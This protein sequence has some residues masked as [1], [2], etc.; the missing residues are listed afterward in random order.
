MVP[1]V[2]QEEEDLLARRVALQE[3][4]STAPA[5]SL[6][7]LRLLR[8]PCR[9]RL[10]P[11]PLLLRRL[12]W[13]SSRGSSSVQAVLDPQPRLVALLA[14]HALGAAVQV[15]HGGRPGARPER[16]LVR[17]GEDALLR[18]SA[19]ALA[20]AA[21]TPTT[22]ALATVALATADATTLSPAA[23]A[24]GCASARAASA[25]PLSGLDEFRWPLTV[26]G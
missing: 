22:T 16:L 23:C 7:L 4:A 17:E 26:T 19:A 20:G 2:S 15:G 3:A 13:L 11:L 5:R 9:L 12:R 24:R 10:A 21:L 14:R 1:A 18:C 8:L 25:A 6:P